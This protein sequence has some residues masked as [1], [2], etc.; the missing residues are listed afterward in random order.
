MTITL[1]NLNR[2]LGDPMLSVGC[3]S[4]LYVCLS[5]LSVTL[6]YCGQTVGRIEMKLGTPVG[7]GAGHI[8]LGGDPAP[9][10]LKRHS[11]QFLASVCCGQMAGWTNMPLG[12][13]VGRARV[14]WRFGVIYTREFAQKY[15]KIYSAWH[16]KTPTRRPASADRTACRQFQATGQP[17]S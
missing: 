3:L 14:S 5:C 6:V 11:P 12:M 15:A 1:A 16:I 7:L 2:F 13:E 4:F 8:V 10:P 9:P 17:V